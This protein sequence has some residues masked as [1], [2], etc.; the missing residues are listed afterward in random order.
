MARRSSGAQPAVVKVA[1]FAGGPARVKSLLDYLSRQGELSVEDETGT[2]IHGR[3]QVLGFL[4][5][6]W[7]AF[8]DGRLE[9]SRL[10]A[11]GSVVAAEGQFTGTHTGVMR[12]PAGDVAATGRHVDVPWMSS[13]EIRGDELASEHL[14]FDQAAMLSQLGLMPAS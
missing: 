3:E 5:V 9:T 7:D 2:E 6:F 1:S 8:P 13:Y 14:Y 12:T 10:L 11:E 4:G